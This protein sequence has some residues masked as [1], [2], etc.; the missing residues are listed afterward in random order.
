ML[1]VRHLLSKR[2]FF[3]FSAVA[4]ITFATG[5]WNL[6]VVGGYYRTHVSQ[7]TATYFYCVAVKCFMKFMW[8]WEMTIW[9]T[10]FLHLFLHWENRVDW[11]LLSSVSFVPLVDYFHFDFSPQFIL[12]RRYVRSF[13]RHFRNKQLIG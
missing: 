3:F 8:S 5:L 12:G 9:G 1:S 2:T 6:L 13:S 11:T 7:T 4:F 10:T